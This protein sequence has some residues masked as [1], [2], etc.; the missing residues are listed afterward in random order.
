M[1]WLTGVPSSSTVV[2]VERVLWITAGADIDGS[3][4]TGSVGAGVDAD[5]EGA[6]VAGVVIREAAAEADAVGVAAAAA[7]FFLLGFASGS[8]VGVLVGVSSNCTALRRDEVTGFTTAVSFSDLLPL[9]GLL[10][11]M[12]EG[13]MAPEPRLTSISCIAMSAN[14]PL[15]FFLPIPLLFLLLGAYWDTTFR[16]SINRFLCK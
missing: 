11:A 8:G 6:A 4:A 14:K 9:V 2:A 1:R 13:D 5:V 7:A 12:D 16:K 10:L 3:T 15:P